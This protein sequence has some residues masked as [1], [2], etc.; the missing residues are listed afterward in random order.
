MKQ[1]IFGK[2]PK[3]GKMSFSNNNDYG[4]IRIYDC[5]NPNIK[6]GD[7]EITNSD[8]GKE[9]CYI[10]FKTQSDI[11]ELIFMVDINVN[12]KLGNEFELIF[13]DNQKS[14]DVFK[15]WLRLLIKRFEERGMI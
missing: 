7:S 4:L 9:L 12:I 14:V 8:Y 6:I 15:N 11:I 2:T 5:I 1:I 3:L 13:K 10:P